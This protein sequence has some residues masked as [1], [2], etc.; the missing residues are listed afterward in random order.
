MIA[1]MFC[2]WKL[3]VP[4]MLPP[5]SCTIFFPTELLESLDSS[6][7][8][9]LWRMVCDLSLHIYLHC[10][11]ENFMRWSLS[12]VKPTRKLH[13][14]GSGVQYILIVQSLSHHCDASCYMQRHDCT[15]A[16]ISAGSGNWRVGFA[17]ALDL[18]M[19]DF[20]GRIPDPRWRG[21]R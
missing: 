7:G 5:V 16:S 6:C 4:V 19:C 18:C 1:A 12:C 3:P 9:W 2:V 8:I 13:I 10:F 21:W 14:C 15:I 17:S 20:R 11:D